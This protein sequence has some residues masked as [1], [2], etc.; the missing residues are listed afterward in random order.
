MPEIKNKT[1]GLK[2]IDYSNLMCSTA[3]S[4]IFENNQVDTQENLC[5]DDHDTEIIEPKNEEFLYKN[6]VVSLLDSFQSF[7]IQL[8]DFGEEIKP[9]KLSFIDYGNDDDTYIFQITAIS[10]ELKEIPLLAI[11]FSVEPEIKSHEAFK[12][13]EELVNDTVRFDVKLMGKLN[14]KMMVKLYIC[15]NGIMVSENSL[16]DGSVFSDKPQVVSKTQLEV[17]TVVSI[18][19]TTFDIDFH[20]TEQP[21]PQIRNVNGVQIEDIRIRKGLET[22]KGKYYKIINCL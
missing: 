11:N 12:K 9:G 18:N 16:L 1:D 22:N 10:K 8:E 7:Y 20:F 4:I 5:T 2:E 17:K 14:D 15:K 3:D 19:K 6:V 13:F 21:K